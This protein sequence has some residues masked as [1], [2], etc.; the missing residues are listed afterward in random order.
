MYRVEERL[1]RKR[2]GQHEVDVGR[3][4]SRLVSTQE[5][6]RR[7]LEIGVILDRVA[8]F[9]A[10]PPGQLFADQRQVGFFGLRQFERQIAIC[11]RV[12]AVRLAAQ[13]RFGDRSNGHT[14]IGNQYG[15]GHAFPRL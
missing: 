2:F 10:R 3:R 12:H 11:R 13:E 6:N 9:L 1:R 4:P 15:R 8:D 5:D 14:F 7:I